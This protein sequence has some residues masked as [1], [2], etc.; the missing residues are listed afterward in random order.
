MVARPKKSGRNRADMSLRR[1]VETMKK[2]KD[3]HRFGRSDFTNA[4]PVADQTSDVAASPVAVRER[5]NSFRRKRETD[6][7]YEG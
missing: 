4:G 5:E 7:E 2:K 3:S 1:A 6:D